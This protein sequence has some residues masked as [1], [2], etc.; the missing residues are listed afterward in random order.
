[1]RSNCPLHVLSAPQRWTMGASTINST[2]V[3]RYLVG[4]PGAA[5]FPC[6]HYN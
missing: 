3:T 5:P 6:P 2:C 1:M 4:L